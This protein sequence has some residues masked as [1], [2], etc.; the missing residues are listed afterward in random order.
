[1][2]LCPSWVDSVAK[3]VLPRV[4]KFLRAAGAFFV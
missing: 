4:S 1:L 3:V 2:F